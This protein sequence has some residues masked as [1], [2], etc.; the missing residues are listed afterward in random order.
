MG[1]RPPPTTLQPPLRA[2]RARRR[3]TG[4]YSPRATRP[5]ISLLSVPTPRS[6]AAPSDPTAPHRSGPGADPAALQPLVAT[7]V[8]AL[9]PTA[10]RRPQSAPRRPGSPALGPTAPLRAPQPRS[11]PH[12]PATSGP[13]RSNLP[14]APSRP[15]DW[16][17][18]SLPP[19][20]SSASRD[21]SLR[22]GHH[23]TCGPSP[24]GWGRGW[25]RSHL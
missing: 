9:K 13:P 11:A 21:P 18:V 6:P 19:I 5:A 15:S 2:Y 7:S 4:L 16:P 3:P 17:L 20:G 10:P 12:S 14:A 24:W 25:G 23:G 8:A 22:A 1:P